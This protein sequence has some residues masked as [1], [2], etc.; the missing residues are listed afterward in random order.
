M[1][2]RLVNHIGVAEEISQHAGDQK[3]FD[4]ISDQVANCMEKHKCGGDGHLPLLPDRVVWIEANNSSRIQL[5]EPKGIRAKYIAL[6]YCW[7]TGPISSDTYLTDTSTLSAKQAGMEYNDL[8]PLFQDVVNCARKLGI[9]YIWIDRLCIIQ[10]ENGDFKI[11]APKM[12]DIYGNA[13]LTIAA[14][15][16]TSENDRILVEREPKWHASDLKLNIEGFGSLKLRARRRTHPIGEEAKGGDYGKVSTRAWI[17]QERLLSGRTVFY[18]PS[19]LKFE[20]HCHSVWEGFGPRITGISWSAKLES[21]SHLSWL[22]LVEEFMKRDIT[23]PYDRLPAMESVMKRIEKSKGWSPLCGLWS[24][25]FRESPGWSSMEAGG[26]FSGKIA[27]RM[28]PE[29]YAPTWS[30]ASVNGPISYVSV[31][32]MSGWD[33]NNPMIYDMEVRNINAP[34]GMVTIAARIGRAQL[35]CTVELNGMYG[36]EPDEPRYN[37]HYGVKDPTSGEL[38]PI[39]P[40]VALKPWSGNVNGQNLSTVIRVPY[41]EVPPEQSWSASCLCVLVG[42]Q[43]LRSLVLFMGGSLR[44]SGA[45]E[46][47][48]MASGLE[49]AIFAGA[50]KGIVDIV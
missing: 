3:C 33:G 8:P 2:S 10:G 37:Y 44:E 36:F 12:G 38:F 26:A 49:P 23:K 41:G 35:N 13:T 19:A 11:Q 27:C 48:G 14:A 28:N 18:T 4:F 47:L 34:L 6:S 1:V 29:H 45:W 50:K 42:Y 15:S 22:T 16:A 46:R 40:D 24:N 17:W 20:C 43:S 21:I 7:A 32:V 5:L 39:K 9:Q 31:R 25:A 30:W